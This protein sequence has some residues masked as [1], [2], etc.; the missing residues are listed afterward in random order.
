MSC[1]N[2]LTKQEQLKKLFAPYVNCQKCPLATQGR[3]QVVFGSGDAQATLMF[4]GEGPGR[5]EDL[6]GSPFVGRSGQLLTKIIQAMGLEREQVYISNVVKCRPP[7]NRT[8]LPTETSTCKQLLL[9][10]EIEIIQPKV[11]CTL[12]APAAKALLGEDVQI[13]RVRGI[14]AEFKGITVMPTYHPAYLLRNPVEK[15]TVWEDM[16]KIMAKIQ[17]LNP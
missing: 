8:P 14:F 5:D 15:R 6:Q 1:E 13:S 2:T 11:I 12:G 17:E 9:L 3:T 10:K 16:K 4:I 7:N